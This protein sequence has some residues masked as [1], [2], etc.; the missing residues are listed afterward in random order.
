MIQKIFSA[1]TLTFG[2]SLA[3]AAAFAHSAFTAVELIDAAKVVVAQ[4]TA[5][6]PDLVRDV[7]G[8]KVWKSG[9]AAKVKVYYRGD[10]Q[11]NQEANYVCN[12]H[13]EDELTVECERLP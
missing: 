1:A 3:P 5:D 10:N 7:F 8:Y 9:E 13:G 2:L 4:F 6:S 12:K 11:T